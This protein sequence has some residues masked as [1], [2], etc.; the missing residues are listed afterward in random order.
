MKR[1][2]AALVL[3]LAMVISPMQYVSAAEE[4]DQAA[5][6][7]SVSAAQ[8]VDEG[9]GETAAQT[10]NTE[11]VKAKAQSISVQAEEFGVEDGVLTAETTTSTSATRPKWIDGKCQRLLWVPRIHID[12]PRTAVEQQRMPLDGMPG[13][14]GFVEVEDEE[15]PF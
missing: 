14:D 13:T 10:D 11:S 2:V 15:L 9:S 4:Q 6:Q 3:S 12:G 8:P 5:G 1:K 7:T